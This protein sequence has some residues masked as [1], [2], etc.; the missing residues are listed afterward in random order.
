MN[1]TEAHRFDQEDHP[2]YGTYPGPEI[3]TVP[4]PS[5][6]NGFDVPVPS[7]P[8]ETSHASS[9]HHSDGHH[10]LD[11]YC[12][13]TTTPAAAPL[14]PVEQFIPPAAEPGGQVGFHPAPLHPEND[15]DE[16]AAAAAHIDTFAAA[17]LP[18]DTA[19]DTAPDLRARGRSAA[20][21]LMQDLWKGILVGREV[22]IQ[23]DRQ[24]VSQ[25]SSACC[26]LGLEPYRRSWWCI[27]VRASS[28]S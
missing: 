20:N 7:T 12:T 6:V 4:H 15:A 27:C 8:S 3:D 13:P 2:E 26:K 24:F 19:P 28:R 11:Y 21:E 16:P 22:V 25:N 9:S 14:Q 10:S 5:D 1:S 23:S 17:L 18:I